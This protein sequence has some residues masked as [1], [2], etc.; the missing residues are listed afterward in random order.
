MR[1][2]S[3]R[4]TIDIGAQQLKDARW[5]YEPQ[6]KD[7]STYIT[8]YR[9]RFV[10][11]DQG[12]GD[13]RNDS[14]LDATATLALRTLKNGMMSYYTSPA[15]R[16]MRLSSGDPDLDEYAP[17]KYWLDKHGVRMLQLFANS[18]TYE[19][20]PILYGDMAGFATGVMSME[21]HLERVFHHRT[22]QVGSVWVGVDD[23]GDTTQFYR[24]YRGTVR[25]VIDTFARKPG[26][27]DID[28]SRVSGYVKK[29]WD[30]QSYNTMVD[31]GHMIWP[32]EDYD[33]RRLDSKYK[34]F[35]SCYFELG[36]AEQAQGYFES[37]IDKDKFLRESGF[38]LFPILCGRWE[39]R[40]GEAYGID[41]PAMTCIGD[42][43][44]LQRSEKKENVAIDKSV[45]PPLVGPP[46]L[47]T[48]QNY[49]IPG[50][51]TWLS[52]REGMKGLRPIYEI[53]PPIDKIE[54]KSAQVRSRIKEAHYVDLFRMFDSMDDRTR[55]ATEIIERR[56]EKLTQLGQPLQ[57]LNRGV[58]S[59]M[60]DIGFAIMLRQGMVEKPPRELW[61]RTLNVEY[62]GV[63]AQAQK[64]VG[65]SSIDR[66]VNSAVTI[67]GIYPE[68]ADAV[69][70]DKV[71]NEYATLG[72]AP[73]KIMVDPEIVT[74]VREA[75]R[76][77][78]AA[79]L[80]GEQVERLTKAG[81]T[82]SET[83][84]DEKS[85]LTDLLKGLRDPAGAVA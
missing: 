26:T 78:Q 28:W 59:R 12:R 22:F 45:D 21:E 4:E 61:G 56:Q 74:K 16:W 43:K 48:Q 11:S 2:Y 65:L 14:I 85:A 71:L 83:S 66:V 10:L 40:E 1:Y 18:N 23:F 6:W 62:E 72:G 44:Q 31:I 67:A 35:A 75:R 37:A 52:E 82:L 77:Q 13:R 47:K 63:L 57:N 76:A 5:S 19:A 79:Q 9:D 24:E 81:K 70:W 15:A 8:P 36:N 30:D 7:V 84:T 3:K 73:A 32:N 60:I 39:S 29:L 20:L 25:N 53:D 46:E 42:V 68:I 17:V 38:D 69:D 58:L 51:I 54:L 64:A 33:A 55:T 49:L 80:Q 27:R 41:C 50:K 34:P